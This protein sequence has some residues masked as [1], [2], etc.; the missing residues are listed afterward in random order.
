MKYTKTLV[1]TIFLLAFLISSFASI[2]AVS[3]ESDKQLVL[4]GY[5]YQVIAPTAG[6][7]ISGQY[8]VIFQGDYNGNPLVR[9]RCRVYQGSTLLVGWV[10]MTQTSD[11]FIWEIIWDTESFDDGGNY[12]LRFRAYRTSR[13]ST[14]NIYSGYVTIDNSGGP[15]TTPPTVSITSPADGA[16]VGGTVTISASASDNVGVT[17]VEFYVDDVLKGTDTSSPYSYS[18]GTTAYSDGLHDLKAIAY[19]AADN[20]DTD[21]I[22]VTVDNSGP[23]P[24]PGLYPW[25][26]DLIDAEIAH[27]N[28]YT[29]DGT[30]VV[31]IDTGL[32]SNWATDYFDQEDILT[33]YCFSQTKEKG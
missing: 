7:T 11:P 4:N 21:I 20:T 5:N 9:V 8:L 28:G 23:P 12:R 3:E 25:W 14:S 26:N 18:W 2:A 30:V 22:S 6:E 19:D 27:A 17:K 15:D 13:R 24:P 1:L 29:G 16:T 32:V 10:D 31:I 33:Q